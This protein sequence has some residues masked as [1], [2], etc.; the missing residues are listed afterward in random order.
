MTRPNLLPCPYLLPSAS[1]DGLDKLGVGVTSP[2][3][4]THHGADIERHAVLLDLQFA[5]AAVL[6]EQ[7]AGLAARPRHPDAARVDG[8]DAAGQPVGP[9]VGVPADHHVGVAT[10]QQTA[11][12]RVRDVRV[13]AGAV[14]GAR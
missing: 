11:E 10:G 13:D 1:E 6:E 2:V 5:V 12:F 3:Q 7:P 14:I 4:V 9:V 8:A